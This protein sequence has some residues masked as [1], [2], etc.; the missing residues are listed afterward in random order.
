MTNGSEHLSHRFFWEV[1][2][3]IFCPFS[4]WTVYFLTGWFVFLLLSCQG[5]FILNTNSFSDI[6]VANIFSQSVACLCTFLMIS[7]KEQK[8]LTLIETWF[9]IFFFYGLWYVLTISIHFFLTWTSCTICWK[10]FCFLTKLSFPLCQNNWP[11][12]CSSI[13]GLSYL[14]YWSIYLY[15]H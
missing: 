5:S 2:V 12:T 9:I 14:F 3:Q 4:H 6:Y 8:A 1:S 11:N 10:D 13:F 7:F 15:L